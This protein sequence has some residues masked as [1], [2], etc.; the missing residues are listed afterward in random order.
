[1]EKCDLVF[2]YGT[3]KKGW[4]NNALLATSE[5]LGERITKDEYVLVGSGCP[6]MLPLSCLEQIL[7]YEDNP[8]DYHRLLRP[9]RGELYRMDTEWT[10]ASL[11][12]LESEGSWY[13]RVLIE[14]NQGETAWS[15][16]ILDPRLLGQV[17]LCSITNS[18][19]WQWP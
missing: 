10:L 5:Y 11:D 6:F 13:Q 12:G 8:S 19:E 16:Q 15:Y 2:V 18:G 7:D 17:R 9:V 14:T 1:M 4:G 3:L